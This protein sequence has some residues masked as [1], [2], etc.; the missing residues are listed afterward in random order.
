MRFFKY[1][2]LVSF[3]FLSFGFSWVEQGKKNSPQ[4]DQSESI[5]KTEL[6]NAQ[7]VTNS[8]REGEANNAQQLSSDLVGSSEIIKPVLPTGFSGSNRYSYAGIRDMARALQAA[9]DAQSAQQAISG[10]DIVQQVGS[11][12]ASSFSGKDPEIIRIQKQINQVIKAYEQFKELDLDQLGVLENV[13]NEV[14][15]QRETLNQLAEKLD[16]EKL[17]KKDSDKILEQEKIRRQNG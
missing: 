13:V 3:V 1:L 11:L 7:V 2:F 17:T 12:N 9:K 5:A 10:S 14:S 4:Q 16:D 6:A 8:V 15:N